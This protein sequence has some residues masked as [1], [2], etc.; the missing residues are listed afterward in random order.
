MTW[1]N[2]PYRKEEI[3]DVIGVH[4]LVGLVIVL[5][6]ERQRIQKKL[7]SAPVPSTNTSKYKYKIKKKL[8]FGPLQL[9]LRAHVLH[10]FK[11]MSNTLIMFVTHFFYSLNVK[12][13]KKNYFVHQFHR[14]APQNTSTKSKKLWFGPLQLCLRANVLH[15]FKIMSNTLMMCVPHF[16]YSL[17][18]RES[19]K[20]YFVHQ[21]HR[22]APQNTSTK[23]KK[24]WFGPLQLCLRAHVLHFFKIMS[25]TLMMF[26]THFFYSLNV[27]ESKKNY[28]VHQFHRLA[29]QNTSTK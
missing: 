2:Q 21:F 1:E 4:H 24:L 13:F 12:E 11:I 28:F 5:V 22:L 23:S 29:P 10:F 6:I 8:W 15:F 27:K 18:V 26:V 16:F 3:R 19:K 17:N 25:N 20:N 7:F 14:I 9:C